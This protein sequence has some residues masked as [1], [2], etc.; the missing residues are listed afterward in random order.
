M[1]ERILRAF[2][3]G[4]GASGKRKKESPPAQPRQEPAPQRDISSFLALYEGL[5]PQHD[6][7]DE[8]ALRFTVRELG[9]LV[10]PSGKIEASDPLRYLGTGL[11]LEVPHGAYPV[12]ATLVQSKGEAYTTEAYLSVVLADAQSVRVESATATPLWDGAD[13]LGHFHSL[14]GVDSGTAG[15]VDVGSLPLVL[16]PEQSDRPALVPGGKLDHEGLDTL[17]ALLPDEGAGSIGLPGGQRGENLILCH[18]GQGDGA[19]E[20][21][22]TFASDG[23]ATGIHI[24][25]G[26]LGFEE[27][28]H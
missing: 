1:L 20:V 18:S 14:I 21:L 25:F 10:C 27:D 16:P 11:A 19:Y 28:E 17:L 2:S 4:K 13:G 15:F 9:T 26:L 22:V 8:E 24:D 3:G 7:D 23:R 5:A 12:R 6:P